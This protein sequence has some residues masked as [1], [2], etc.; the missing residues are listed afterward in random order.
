MDDCY[1]E[2]RFLAAS[3]LALSTATEDY[4]DTNSPNALW[5]MGGIKD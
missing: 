1:A 5:A 3:L 4:V 2:A